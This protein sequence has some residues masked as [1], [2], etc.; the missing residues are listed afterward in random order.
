MIIRQNNKMNKANQKQLRQLK[1]AGVALLDH[2]PGGARLGHRCL[3][4]GAFGA[5][6]ALNRTTC[7]KVFEG[8]SQPELEQ[9]ALKEVQDLVRAAPAAPVVPRALAV[10]LNPPSVVMSRHGPTFGK[11]TM[12]NPL[13]GV[14]V[15]Q[16]CQATIEAVQ[17]L[18]SCGFIHND[19]K[20]D[21]IT[22]DVEGD[23]FSVTLIDLG[24]LTRVG[25]A[26]PATFLEVQRE[27]KYR[28]WTR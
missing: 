21:N 6:F 17:R 26:A 2:L 22:V 3:G 8:D 5:V 18:H 13:S 1:E 23:A 12:T 4:S 16:I 28:P 27:T 24:M 25:E 20:P 11:L 10:C 15:L 7:L 19:I 14:Q 9:M